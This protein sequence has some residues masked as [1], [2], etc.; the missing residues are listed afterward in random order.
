MIY[1][2]YP[3]I[4]ARHQWNTHVDHVP[5]GSADAAE[6]LAGLAVE[7]ALP[8]L[9]DRGRNPDTVFQNQ[10]GNRFLIVAAPAF[11]TH[12]RTMLNSIDA[13]LGGAAD[14]LSTMAVRCHGHTCFVR[15]ADNGAQIVLLELGIGRGAA[16]C[17]RPPVAMTLIRSTPCSSCRSSTCFASPRL[18][19][20]PPQK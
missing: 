7:H 17:R 1:P 6:D 12:P 11:V 2:R 3:R 8:T 4:G 18:S 16:R 10:S 20:P 13:C 9:V 15:H 14:T 19:A 5:V